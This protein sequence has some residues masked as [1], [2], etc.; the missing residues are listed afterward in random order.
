MEKTACED[1]GSE[2]MSA[3]TWETWTMSQHT[4]AKTQLS[5]KNSTVRKGVINVNAL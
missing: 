2:N 3:A 4:S 5:N 1:N